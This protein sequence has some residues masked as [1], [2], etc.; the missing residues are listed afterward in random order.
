MLEIL[1]AFNDRL[2]E[3]NAHLDE[4]EL[5]T[6]NLISLNDE[7]NTSGFIVAAEGFTR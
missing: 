3:S 7:R 4:D 1:R 2:R 5:S 6:V